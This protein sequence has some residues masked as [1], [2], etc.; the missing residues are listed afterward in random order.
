MQNLTQIT[1]LIFLLAGTKAFSLLDGAFVQSR[2][3]ASTAALSAFSAAQDTVQVALTREEGKN[4]K[5][6]KALQSL[7]KRM[8]AVELPCIA[9]A[10]GPDYDRLDET[11]ASNPWDYVTVTSPEAARVLASAW[12]SDLASIKVAAVGK[13]TEQV[14][15]DNGMDVHFCPS[16]ATAKTLVKELP[17]EAGTSVL[18]PASRRAQLTLEEGLAQR[19][20]E[21]TRLNTYDTVTATWTDNQRDVASSCR[22]ACFASPSAIKGW[23]INT[24]KLGSRDQP[25]LAA[26][27]GETSAQACREQG[28]AEQDI[29]YPDKP[30]IDGW[31]DAVEQALDSLQA[32]ALHE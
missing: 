27:I 22:I 9:H 11:L 16:K 31:V 24:K 21:V 2:R 19:G 30:G 29:F 23:L 12:T 5:L 4:A 32:V 15:R 10:D 1:S 3:A 25:V 6:M 17:G 8:T 28:W 13:A 20:F 7:S 26:C 14:L 18:Y